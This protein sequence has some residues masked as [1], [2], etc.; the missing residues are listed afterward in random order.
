MDVCGIDPGLNITGYAVL[1][2][3]PP[4]HRLIE[5]GVIRTDAQRELPDRLL[6]LQS[7]LDQF[8]EQT[9]PD[10]A[11]VEK[12]Y[13]HYKHPRTAILMG[14]AR[15]VILMTA[16]RHGVPVIHLQATAIKRHLTG[17]GRATKAQMQ[18]IIQTTL[19][20]SQLPE[21]PDVADAMAIALCGAH[22]I[23]AKRTLEMQA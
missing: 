5:A 19:N 16:A 10:V 4:A 13:A 14:H 17:H 2:E 20:L 21:P 7:D 23:C 15:G 18:R 8:F 12:L 6:Q 9:R 3:T 22:Q 11:A 1:R